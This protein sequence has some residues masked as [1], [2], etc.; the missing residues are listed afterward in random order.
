MK[1]TVSLKDLCDPSV[2]KQAWLSN[3]DRAKAMISGALGAVEKSSFDDKEKST[4]GHYGRVLSGIE[5]QSLDEKDYA[6]VSSI[7]TKFMA[8]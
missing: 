8:S 7:I 3:D 5:K 4:C 2:L 6:K 1:K